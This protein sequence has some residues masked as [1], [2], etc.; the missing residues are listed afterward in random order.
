MDLAVALEQLKRIEHGGS[1]ALLVRGEA[2]IGK[3]RLAA[4]IARARRARSATATLSGRADDFDRG[5]PY[6]VF[7]DVLR[8]VLGRRPG[9]CGRASTRCARGSTR[10]RRPAARRPT[11]TCRSSSPARSSSSAR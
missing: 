11:R 9:R 6:A 5:I 4:E 7:R 10:P 1:A 3:T 2:G 8:S